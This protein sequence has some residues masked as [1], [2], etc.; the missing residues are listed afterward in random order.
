MRP[1]YN[2]AGAGEL[3]RF[4][5]NSSDPANPNLV[6]HVLESGVPISVINLNSISSSTSLDVALAALNGL[7]PDPT[8][9]EVEQLISAG[10]SFY[11]GMTLELRRRFIAGQSF[12]FSFRASYT[13]SKLLDDGVVNTS[14]ALVPG[15]FRSEQ[16]AESA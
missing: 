11:Q 12:G 4:V 7:R 10:N 2:A 8:R 16:S 9:A 6:G 1:L 5:F 14:D 3:I 13:L 15:D